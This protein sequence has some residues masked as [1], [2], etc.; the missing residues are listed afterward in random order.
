MKKL[1]FTILMILPF[2]SFGQEVKFAI[3]DEVPVYPGCE[4]GTNAEKRKC[5]SDKIAKFVS[6]KFNQN[7]ADD[8]G[9]SGRQH[10]RILFNINNNFAV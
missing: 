10:I 2:V 6:R 3:I 8:L 4:R 1:L 7:L 5:M 9:L